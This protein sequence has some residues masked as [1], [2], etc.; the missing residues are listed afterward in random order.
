MERQHIDRDCPTWGLMGFQQLAP[1]TLETILQH[2]LDC[3]FFF[4]STI[5]TRVIAI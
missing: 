2:V 5:G 3:G 1:K 4:F